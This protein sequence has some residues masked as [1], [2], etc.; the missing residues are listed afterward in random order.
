MISVDVIFSE[1]LHRVDASKILYEEKRVM[2]ELK[3]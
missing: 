1:L 3:K 2:G